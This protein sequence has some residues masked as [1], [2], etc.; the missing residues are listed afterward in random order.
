MVIAFVLV[1]VIN[2]GEI[3]WILDERL[4]YESMHLTSFLFAVLTQTDPLV[5]ILINERSL[6][7]FVPFVA[8][9]SVVANLVV[10]LVA[11]NIFP[12]FALH[13]TSF[14]ELSFFRNI[15]YM[16]VSQSMT[17]SEM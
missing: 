5:T 12:G 7:L 13:Y 15:L 2:A 8:Y 1:N 6:Q 17:G 3:I 10:F 11:D 9:V 16:S 14:E 4:S